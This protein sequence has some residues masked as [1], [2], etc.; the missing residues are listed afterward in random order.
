MRL[1]SIVALMLAL[2]AG[3][4]AQQRLEWNRHVEP[5]RIAGNVYFVGVEGISAFLIRTEAGAIL[6]DGGLPETAPVIVANLKA[7]GVDITEVKQLLHSHAH[8]DH[9]G[10][11]AELKRLSGAS[12]A[13]SAADA[14]VLEAGGPNLPA[15]KVDRI[16]ADGDTVTLGG[17]SLTA[18]L[19]PGHTKGCT[20]W[21]TKTQ[22]GGREYDVLFHCSSSVVDKL[23][24]NAA[25]PNIVEDY[26]ASFAKFRAMRADIM[27]ANHP[28]FFH[29]AEKRARVQ[30]G[31]PN[32]FVDPSELQRFN[33][34][35]E[36]RFKAALEKER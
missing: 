19:T 27:L 15:V 13:V 21:T 7:I 1:M 17:T 6:I 11:L 24:G 4:D 3:Q 8:F 9:V 22:E 33:T 25:Y 36:A 14:P 28:S 32:P 10:G 23:V 12:L 2:G 34:Q 20:T 31:A 29:M 5:F 30:A 26:E 16:I 18:H 35:Q